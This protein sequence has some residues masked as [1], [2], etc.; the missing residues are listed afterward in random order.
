MM[1]MEIPGKYQ[2]NG[3]IAKKKPPDSLTYL[4]VL[5]QETVTKEIGQPFGTLFLS[6]KVTA[7]WDVKKFSKCYSNA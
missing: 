4:N 2:Q 7:Y 3:T 5:L 1:K 6:E